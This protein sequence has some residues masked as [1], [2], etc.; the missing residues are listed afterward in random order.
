MSIVTRPAAGLR[1]PEFPLHRNLITAPGSGFKPF[2]FRRRRAEIN[3]EVPAQPGLDCCPRGIA[4]EQVP[5]ERTGPRGE[6]D[7]ALDL[8]AVVEAGRSWSSCADR[9]TTSY[10]SV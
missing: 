9:A 6:R 10:G 5:V 7:A 4:Q 3:L 8:Q 1:R 2:H